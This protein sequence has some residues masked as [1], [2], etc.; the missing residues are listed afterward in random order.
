MKLPQR[1]ETDRLLLRT[2]T[3]AD[4]PA[5][6]EAVTT[7]LDHLLAFMPWA[8]AE[9]LLLSERVDL[10]RHW[11]GEAERGENLVVGVFLGDVIV[12]GSGLHRRVG[13]DGLEIGYWIHVDHTRRGYASEVSAAL[14]SAA[15]QIPGI[16]RVEIHHDKANVPSSG[17][18]QALRFTLAEER[19]REPQAP[20]E[21]GINCRWIMARSD[22]PT[23]LSRASPRSA[24][25]PRSPATRQD[26]R[27]PEARPVL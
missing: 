15:F 20:A 18:P 8:S 22:W 17:I 19:P 11:Q 16:D 27:T 5:L 9:P 7:S 12:G 24:S 26:R 2:W 6:A 25:M 1:I 3:E 4:A 10:I 21:I 14:T 13:P 23:Q